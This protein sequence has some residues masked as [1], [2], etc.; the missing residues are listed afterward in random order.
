MIVEEGLVKVLAPNVNERGPGSAGG[1]F[2]NREMVFNRDTSIFILYNLNLRDA[3]DALAAT[4][5][6]GIRIAKEIGMEV[7]LNDVNP[8]AVKVMRKN[9]D[10]NKVDVKIEN[11]NANALMAQRRFGYVD[12]DPFGTPVPFIDMALLSGRVLGITA[13]D[14]AT[15]GGRNRRIERRYLSN[16]KAPVE[17]VHEIGVRVLLGYIARMAGRSDLGIEPLLSVWRGHFYRVYVKVIRGVRWARRSLERVGI[18]EFGGPLWK[19]ELHDFE[20]LKNAKIPDWLPTRNLLEKY[21]KIWSDERGFLFYHIPSISRELHV[22]TPSPK[23]VIEELVSMGYYAAPTQFSQ[24]GI[25]SDA[26]PNIVK[27]IIN[28]EGHK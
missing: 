22:S 16:V 13:T 21:I 19:G 26:P 24:Q 10:M 5:V 1:V 28:G 3:L 17:L 27:E 6:R 20:F 23:I 2:Y 8:E 11:T 12:I 9:A 15:L 7:T 14:T 25:R 4:G 18:C